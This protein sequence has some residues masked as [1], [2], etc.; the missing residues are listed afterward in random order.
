MTR[1]LSLTVAAFL[2]TVFITNASAH[3]SNHKPIQFYAGLSGG[4]EL[5]RGDHSDNLVAPAAVVAESRTFA[6]NQSFP[7]SANGVAV[8]AMS[9]ILFKVPNSPIAIG[10]EIYLGQGNKTSTFRVAYFEPNAG[11]DR[12]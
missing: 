3:G 8:T 5:L 2:G 6:S 9:G 7:S 12:V 10:P 4:L 11:E 1:K